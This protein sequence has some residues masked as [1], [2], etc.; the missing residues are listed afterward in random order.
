MDWRNEITSKVEEAFNASVDYA[1]AHPKAGLV[2]VMVLLSAGQTGL[3][4]GWKWTYQRPGNWGGHFLLDLLGPTAY[5]FW[6]GVVVAIAIGG[7]VVVRW[8]CYTPSERK[9][10]SQNLV[11]LF[12]VCIFVAEFLFCPA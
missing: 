8:W 4:L 1:Y 12:Y 3:V 11:I 2:V 10:M 6:L 9:I 7:A 5:R